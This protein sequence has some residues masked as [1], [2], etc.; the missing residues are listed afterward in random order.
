[1]VKFNAVIGRSRRV[2]WSHRVDIIIHTIN[3]PTHPTFPRDYILIFMNYVM[4]NSNKTGVVFL[5]YGNERDKKDLF[6]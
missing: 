5:Y 4:K 6:E 1:M 3:P 2:K